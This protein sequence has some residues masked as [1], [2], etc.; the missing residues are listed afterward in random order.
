MFLVDKNVTLVVKLLRNKSAFMCRV[1]KK[2]ANRILRLLF[3][4]KKLYILTKMIYNLT[5][6][7]LRIFV[8]TTRELFSHSCQMGRG[9]FYG[10]I[11]ICR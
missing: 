4:K 7:V 5:V 3:R 9:K 2:C 6:V 8:R 1:H 11:G 10:Y